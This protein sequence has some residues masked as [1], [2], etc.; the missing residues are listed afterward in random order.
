V[1]VVFEP[2]NQISR[3]RNRGA[4]EAQGKYLIFIDAD[5]LLTPQLLLI[6][7]DNLQSEQCSGGG[8][9]VRFDESGS[10]LARSGVRLWNWLAHHIGL[11]AGCFVYCRRDAYDAIG[12]FSEKVYASEEIW[13]SRGLRQWGK[14]H[15]MSFCLISE[16]AVVSSSR[17]LQWFNPLQQILLV[18]LLTV[19]PF[20]V[21][22]KWLCGFWYKRPKK[23]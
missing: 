20:A 1:T 4:K 18:L 22:F 16:V 2:I 5:T 13:F 8:A 15:G 21:R 11:A 12:G 9:E 14:K 19:F 23:S 3:A 17:K 10:G 6:A 7:L